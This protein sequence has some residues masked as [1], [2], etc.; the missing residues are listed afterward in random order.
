M[1]EVP[2][3]AIWR[4]P[5]QGS[6]GYHRANLHSGRVGMI[7]KLLQHWYFNGAV[8]EGVAPT[9]AV[10]G[11][12]GGHVVDPDWPLAIIHVTTSVDAKCSEGLLENPTLLL[13]AGVYFEAVA[14]FE[15]MQMFAKQ[16]MEAQQNAMLL[17]QLRGGGTPPL[18]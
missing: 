15:N 18:M 2:H 1:D 12:F 9:L 14:N 17:Q 6:F 4:D 10:G 8:E 11:T 13:E 16:M 5:S 3:V 7:A